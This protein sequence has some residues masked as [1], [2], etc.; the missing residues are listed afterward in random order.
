M[1]QNDTEDWKEWHKEAQARKARKRDELSE[2]VERF[3]VNNSIYLQKITP[4]QFRLSKSM[5]ISVDVY[6]TSSKIRL[7]RKGEKVKLVDLYKW[8][9]NHFGVSVK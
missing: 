4:Y 1:Y 8:L 7:L 5:F 9:K 3:A 2:M 6:V